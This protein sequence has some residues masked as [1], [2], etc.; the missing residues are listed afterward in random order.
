MRKLLI[1][2]KENYYCMRKFEPLYVKNV[3]SELVE[4]LRHYTISKY[5]STKYMSVV[6]NQILKEF[7]EREEGKNSTKK[8]GLKTPPR[9]VKILK[10]LYDILFSKHNVNSVNWS[11]VE[12]LI[13][14]EF[15]VKSRSAIYDYFKTISLFCLD[16][17][18]ES[19][20]K[21]L[22][23]DLDKVRNVLKEYGLIKVEEKTKP[24]EI[25]ITKTIKLKASNHELLKMFLQIAYELQRRGINLKEVLNGD[26]ELEN[27][28]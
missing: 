23:F 14:K 12:A 3:E 11:F 24:S 6:V 2:F 9:V 13:R 26:I 1:L 7:F 5:G 17:I 20:E 4:K 22:I 8:N 10:R 28:V 25:E 27:Y 21:Y 19:G 15:G 16:V 18:E